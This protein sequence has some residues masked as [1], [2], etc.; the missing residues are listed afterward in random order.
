M[1]GKR[2][3]FRKRM[4]AVIW[5]DGD[6]PWLYRIKRGAQTCGFANHASFDRVC[7]VLVTEIPKL[8]RKKV[9][10]GR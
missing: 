4:W 3:L 10:R 7:R 2:K 6:Q 1:A 8:P 5:R 9:R